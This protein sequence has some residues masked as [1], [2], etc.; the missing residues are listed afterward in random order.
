[1]SISKANK[2]HLT[3]TLSK[4]TICTILQLEYVRTCN[5][6]DGSASLC[7]ENLIKLGVDLL[8]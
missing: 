4:A 3:S 1:M 5:Y 7:F 6:D 8:Q 2:N